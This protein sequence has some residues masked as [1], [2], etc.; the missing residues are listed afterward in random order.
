MGGKWIAVTNRIQV[1]IDKEERSK[2]V[3]W[4]YGIMFGA[5]G[6]DQIDLGSEQVHHKDFSFN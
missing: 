6:R 3:R 1:G 4:S 2:K 5:F